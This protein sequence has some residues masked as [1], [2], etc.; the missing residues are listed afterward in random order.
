MRQHLLERASFLPLKQHF[1]DP[2]INDSILPFQN[3]FHLKYSK[4]IPNI[5]KE[6]MRARQ[7]KEEKYGF[8]MHSNYYWHKRTKGSN[9]KIR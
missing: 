1:S 4:K 2:I 3:P 8:A 5:F 9:T 6:Y 7:K